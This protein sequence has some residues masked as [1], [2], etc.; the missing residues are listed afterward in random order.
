[1]REAIGT[2]RSRFEIVLSS[3][4]RTARFELMAIAL[5]ALLP[6]WLTHAMLLAPFP[7]PEMVAFAMQYVLWRVLYEHRIP[8][9]VNAAY[10]TLVEFLLA[11]TGWQEGPLSWSLMVMLT[12]LSLSYWCAMHGEKQVRRWRARKR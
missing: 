10:M 3:R 2:K 12:A 7:F 8:G 6:A 11:H 1:M 9:A 5:V 4:V